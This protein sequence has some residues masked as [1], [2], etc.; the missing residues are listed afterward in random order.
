MNSTQPPPA[1]HRRPAKVR[2]SG[3]VMAVIF[4]SVLCILLASMLKWVLTEASINRRSMLN[5][6]ARN[7]SEAIAEY[8]FVQVRYQ[9]DNSATFLA[10]AFTSSGAHPLS[11]PPTDLF[12]GT[13]V[14]TTASRLVG[15]TL[16]S[17]IT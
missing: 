13:H 7:A 14:D 8:G 15:G 16:T 3:L 5:L 4:S 9:M 17:I 1:Q 10:N 2:G 6:E 11:L 12:A